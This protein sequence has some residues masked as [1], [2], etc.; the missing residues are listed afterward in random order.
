MGN[1]VSTMKSKYNFDPSEY[2]NTDVDH[3]A[4][5]SYVLSSTHVYEGITEN[6]P[7]SQD[8][9]THNQDHI[10]S[11]IVIGGYRLAYMIKTIFGNNQVNKSTDFL[12]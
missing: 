7:L 8:Y 10:Q 1:T 3:W 5:E 11:Q 9:I 2:Q 4:D 6:K 12:Q